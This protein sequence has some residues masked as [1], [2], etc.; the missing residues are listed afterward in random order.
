MVRAILAAITLTA[1]GVGAVRADPPEHRDHRHEQH[2]EQGRPPFGGRQPFPG[3]PPFAGRPT[4]AAPPPF[5]ARRFD[6]TV[7]MPPNAYP[8]FRGGRT[9]PLDGVV[10]QF[11]RRFP[12]G[13]LLDAEMGDLD[14]RTVY[15]VHWA[16]GDGRRIDYVVDAQTGAVIGEED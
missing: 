12:R 15:H 16:T 6:H 4:Y 3:R 14:G 11:H 1:L 10:G 8:K 5:V 2:G 9:I 13:R 7:Q